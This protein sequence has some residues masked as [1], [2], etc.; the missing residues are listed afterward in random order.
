MRHGGA[1]AFWFE[2]K[3]DK[4]KI[5]FLL[6]DNGKGV[7]IDKLQA[8]FGLSAMKDRAKALGGEVKFA[9]EPDDGFELELIMQADNTAK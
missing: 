5:R 3:K 9:S 1:T 2:L 8:G 4:D 6:S 7:D